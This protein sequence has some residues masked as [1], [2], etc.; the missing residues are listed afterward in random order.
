MGG[1]GVGYY[2]GSSGNTGGAYRSTD[3]DIEATQNGGYAVGWA[4][5]GEWL[6]YSV[7]VSSGANYR[8]VARVASSGGGGTFHVEFNGIDRTGSM[9]IPNTG[10][11]STYQDLAVDVYLDPG[12]AADAPRPRLEWIDGRGR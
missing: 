7:N 4:Y 8:L 11:W 1:N 12:R 3:V 6:K 10:G 2:D 9:R 5:A